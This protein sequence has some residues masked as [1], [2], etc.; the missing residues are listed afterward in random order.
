MTK[1]LSPFENRGFVDSLSRLNLCGK[2][3]SCFT[4]GSVPALLLFNFAHQRFQAFPLGGAEP[5]LQRTVDIQDGADPA[6]FM[7]RDNI[8]RLLTGKENK[9]FLASYFEKRDEKR[10]EKREERREVRREKKEEK[11]EKRSS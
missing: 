9:I 3:C 2:A 1:P 10:G 8:G 11:A 4:E 6:V 7:H 5:V